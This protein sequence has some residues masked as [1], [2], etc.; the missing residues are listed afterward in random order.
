VITATL[1]VA[2][3]THSRSARAACVIVMFSAAII[4]AIAPLM[5]IGRF[6]DA[7]SAEAW[8]AP[9]VYGEAWQSG[10]IA[11]VEAVRSRIAIVFAFFFGLSVLAV[12]PD[13]RAHLEG[14][15]PEASLIGSSV[16]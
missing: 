4:L 1:A 10:R 2:L 11:T 6:A 3:A 15:E 16:I 8:N 9:A 5:I 12:L 13:G 14:A 7:P